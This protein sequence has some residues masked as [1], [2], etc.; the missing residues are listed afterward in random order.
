MLVLSYFINNKNQGSR[1]TLFVRPWFLLFIMG[2]LFR[3]FLGKLELGLCQ[4]FGH[5]LEGGL[6]FRVNKKTLDFCLMLKFLMII[7]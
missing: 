4:Y 5:I 7:L 2:N 1:L 3:E 6:Y